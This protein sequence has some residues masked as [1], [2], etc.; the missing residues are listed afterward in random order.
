M[1]TGGDSVVYF[2][3]LG[4]T[5]LH[6]LVLMLELVMMCQITFMLSSERPK[7]ILLHFIYNYSVTF[8]VT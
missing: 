8:I 1:T 4:V 5:W 7:I 6:L 3:S 2:L